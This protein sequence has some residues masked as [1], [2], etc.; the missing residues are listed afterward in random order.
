MKFLSIWA[1]C[2]LPRQT[3]R[4]WLW[5]NPAS[6]SKVHVQWHII[7][8]QCDVTTTSINFHHLQ[9]KSIPIQQSL[10]ISPFTNPWQ[11]WIS[12]HSASGFTYFVYLYKC[13][14]T[15][16]ELLCLSF[17]RLTKCFWCSC[18]LL[19]EWVLHSFLSWIIFHCMHIPHFLYA[20][21]YWRVGLFSSCGYLEPC[22]MN[23]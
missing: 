21:I 5:T 18:T 3:L 16:Y 15:K 23:N 22:T 1:C 9:R 19:H 10:P 7:Y 6:H 13:S 17:L 8:S 2:L 20:F 12:E 11:Q 14:D 4:P